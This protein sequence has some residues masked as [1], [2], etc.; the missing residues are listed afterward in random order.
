MEFVFFTNIS[1]SKFPLLVHSS[2]NNVELSKKAKKEFDI[3]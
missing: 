1:K 3:S 2:D